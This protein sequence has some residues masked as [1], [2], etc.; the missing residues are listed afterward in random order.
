MKVNT[1]V[2]AGEDDDPVL[3]TTLYTR[4]HIPVG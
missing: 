1:N 3:D 4:I 2:K